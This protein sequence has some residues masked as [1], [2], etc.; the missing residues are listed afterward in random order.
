MPS[1]EQAAKF[2]YYTPAMHAAS[3]VLP[4][5]AER[6]IAAARRGTGAACSAVANVSCVTTRFAR[7]SSFVAAGA[8]VFLLGAALGAVVSF[9]RR[10]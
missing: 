4:P 6:R 8:A 5:F 9:A 1:G 10:R 3:F 2:R 7:Q